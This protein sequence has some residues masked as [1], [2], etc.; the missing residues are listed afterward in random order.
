MKYIDLPN[1]KRMSKIGLGA[2]RFGTRL[3]D[4]LAVDMLEQFLTAGGTLVDT[5]RNYDEWTE[6]GRGKSESFLG[7]WI[8]K[9]RC[10][11]E[12][13][14]VTKGGVSNAEKLFR[15]DLSRNALLKELD[16][17]LEALRTDYLDI[18]L[19][20]RDDPSWSVED[21]VDTFQEIAKR[22]N[23][24][25]IG[26]CNWHCERIRAANHY[27][28]NHGL[29]PIQVVQTWWSIASY[30]DTMWDDPMTTHMDQETYEYCR[31][32]SC[33]AM[34]YTSQAKGFFQKAFTAGVGQLNPMLKYRML[35][36]ENEKKLKKIQAY[37][38]KI[39]CTATDVVFEF[40]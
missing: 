24:E 5:A 13:V 22:A 11:E 26:V 34:A 3:S 19:L 31:K 38:A 25:T 16:E 37:C 14:L 40:S 10:R 2:G 17:S 20:H 23:C 8:E 30:T 29:I 9:N 12:I 35:T 4:K 15:V 7:R 1:G 21:I 33:I 18:Y 39:G 32:H 6:N 27:A 36:E 28:K